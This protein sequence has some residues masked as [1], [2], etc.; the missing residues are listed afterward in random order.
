[1]SKKVEKLSK[2]EL[3]NILK[4]QGKFN[5][6]LLEIGTLEIR[7]ADVEVAWRKVNEEMN[8]V[9]K[10]LQEKY[11]EVNIDLKNGAISELEKENE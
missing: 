7:K 6:F 1:M 8:E 10:E 3:D 5:G 11:G 4:L 2:E 9:K